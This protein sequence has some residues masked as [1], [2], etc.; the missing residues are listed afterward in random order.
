[1]VGNARQSAAASELSPHEGSNLP[2]GEFHRRKGMGRSKGR[3]ASKRRAVANS[4]REQEAALR[5]WLSPR[6]ASLSE[7]QKTAV[8]LGGLHRDLQRFCCREGAGMAGRKAKKFPADR[9]QFRRG[10]SSLLLR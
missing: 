10:S 4:N 1:M 8:Y 9:P 6:F 5:F 7:A 2:A 3:A